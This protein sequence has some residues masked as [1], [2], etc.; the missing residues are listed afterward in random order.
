MEKVGGRSER[1]AT[2]STQQSK[3]AS[4]EVGV[5]QIARGPHNRLPERR[6]IFGPA[7]SARR[8][9]VFDVSPVE[10]TPRRA[11]G[12]AQPPAPAPAPR[13]DASLDFVEVVDSYM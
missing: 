1:T 11:P 6:D 7:R 4:L 9:A 5:T 2:V 8:S 12:R 10:E 13:K 3:E